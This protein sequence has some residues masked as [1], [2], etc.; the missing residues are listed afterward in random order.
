[1][2]ETIKPK[3]DA[4]RIEELLTRRGRKVRWREALVCSCWNLDSGQPAY[5]CKACKGVGYVYGEPIEAIA[6][7][8]S[9]AFNKDFNE[10]A[11]IFEAGDAVMSVPANIKVT[12][13]GRYEFVPMPLFNVGMHDLI[14]LTD[15]DW[16]FTEILIKGQAIG[17]RPPDTFLNSDITRIRQ[18][19]K[20]DPTTG[21]ITNYYQ[22]TDFNLDGNEVV[23][24]PTGNSPAEGEKYSASYFYRPTFTVLVQLPKPRHQDGEDLPKYVVLRHKP[25][26]FTKEGVWVQA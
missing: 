26:G 9:V 12:H 19:F 8:T 3:L 2:A 16:K 4:K 17:K 20:A 7:V 23:W 18:V 25:G 10:Y 5:A 15:D 14:T 6:G 24:I 22:G 21:A 1:M 11:G 13:N